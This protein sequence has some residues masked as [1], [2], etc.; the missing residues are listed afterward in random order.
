MRLHTHGEVTDRGEGD[1]I[2]RGVILYLS[3]RVSLPTHHR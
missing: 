1:A 2:E 3:W